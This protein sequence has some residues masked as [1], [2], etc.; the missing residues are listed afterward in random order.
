MSKNILC[1]D[2]DNFVLN[3]MKHSLCKE[4]S[5]VCVDE[6]DK[7]LQLLDEMCFDMIFSDFNMPKM[8]GLEFFACARTKQPQ[9][10]RILLS[11]GMD[12]K[13]VDDSLANG[14]IHK[15]IEKP[16]HSTELKETVQHMFSTAH[17]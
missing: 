14:L 16:W 1:L 6:G 12:Q 8:S 5:V 9:T 2:D 13:E 17:N 11:G 3:A 4:Y 10:F 15:F 7:A